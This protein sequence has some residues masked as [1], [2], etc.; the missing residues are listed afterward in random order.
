MRVPSQAR[1]LPHSCTREVRTTSAGRNFSTC[2]ECPSGNW[3]GLRARPNVEPHTVRLVGDTD[4]GT[5]FDTGTASTEQKRFKVW[6]QLD[7]PKTAGRRFAMLKAV[8]QLGMS[9]RPAKFEETW[10]EWERQVDVHESLAAS[11]LDD[12]V[13]MTT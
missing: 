12:D 1:E 11:K 8:L 2:G 13:N 9:D 4:H 3:R 10:K 7:A 6:R 5:T